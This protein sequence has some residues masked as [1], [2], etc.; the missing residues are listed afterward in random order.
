[1][2]LTVLAIGPQVSVQDLGRPGYAALGVPVG[3]AADRVALGNANRAVG[4]P[5]GA[6]GFEVLLGGLEL[7]TDATAI[8]AVTG[9]PAPMWRND[10]PVSF[11][12]A[13]SLKPGD[14]L[15]IGTPVIGLRSY[16]ALRGGLCATPLFGSASSNPTAGIGPALLAVGDRWEVGS[17]PSDE[18]QLGFSPSATIHPPSDDLAVRITL[19][20]RADWFTADAL[21]QLTSA[22]WEITAEADRVGVRLS[23]PALSRA[24]EG[25]LASEGVVRGALQVPASGQPIVFGP[26]HPTTGGYPVIGVIVDGDLDTLWQARPGTGVRFHPVSRAW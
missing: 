2:T 12:E 1:M 10:V 14:R 13:I 8:V 20:P 6:P 17:P 26:D 22:R 11:G 24:L 21:R 25:E 23:G 5:A 19:G 7:E 3:G 15:R 18:V 16:V 9:A 4:N